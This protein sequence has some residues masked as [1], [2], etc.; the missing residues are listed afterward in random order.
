MRILIGSGR[1]R[2]QIGGRQV[3]TVRSRIER[4]SARAA[5]R[6]EC[7]LHRV[8]I[9]SNFM[10]HRNSALAVGAEDVLRHRIEFAAV[11]PLA[12]GHTRHRLAR[13]QIGYGHDLIPA[14][15]KAAVMRGI[16]RQAG[17]FLAPRHM[18]ARLQHCTMSVDLRE[19]S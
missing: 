7:L 8:L 16:E 18:P 19:L 15:R 12:D 9:R 3:Q 14:G 4:N 10:H 13:I 17:R 5:L 1:E 11:H 2:T 6:A